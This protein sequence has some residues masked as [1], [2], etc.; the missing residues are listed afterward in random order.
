MQSIYHSPDVH[1]LEEDTIHS[2][3]NLVPTYYHLRD[4]HETCGIRKLLTGERM[5]VHFDPS[6][7]IALS[8]DASPYGIGV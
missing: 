6:K 4:V 3:V 8:C 7:K 1:V 5:L 2:G